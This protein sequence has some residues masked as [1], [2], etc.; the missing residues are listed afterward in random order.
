MITK[1]TLIAKD[2]EIKAAISVEI[3]V[4]SVYYQFEITDWHIN[5]QSIEV[6]FLSLR[7]DNNQ[8]S[9]AIYYPFDLISWTV[10]Q[11][12]YLFSM[13]IQLKTLKL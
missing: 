12:I 9:I 10:A 6:Y 3:T 5:C 11:F 7:S 4:T 2:I 13:K 1:D 8:Q